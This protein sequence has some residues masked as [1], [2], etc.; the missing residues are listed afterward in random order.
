MTVILKDLPKKA[1]IAIDQPLG[2]FA[3]K[4]ALA[5]LLLTLSKLHRLE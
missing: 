4:P 3:M 2:S 1:L 5:P